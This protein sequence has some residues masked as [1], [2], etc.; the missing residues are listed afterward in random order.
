MHLFLARDAYWVSNPRLNILWF[1][2]LFPLL[3]YYNKGSP[4][5]VPRPIPIEIGG[6]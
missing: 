5:A 6:G 2:L 3:F 1:Y 4:L